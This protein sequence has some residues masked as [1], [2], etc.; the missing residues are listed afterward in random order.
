M[1]IVACLYEP[2]ARGMNARFAEQPRTA[3]RA[4]DGRLFMLRQSLPLTAFVRSSMFL[5]RLKRHNDRTPY[6]H[7]ASRRVL[8]A[9]WRARVNAMIDVFSH[10]V[11][12]FLRAA[13]HVCAVLRSFCVAA[14]VCCSDHQCFMVR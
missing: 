3:Y 2:Y 10:K 5:C 12:V 9:R 4:V 11:I 8:H 6:A 13:R 1:G 7:N 14:V